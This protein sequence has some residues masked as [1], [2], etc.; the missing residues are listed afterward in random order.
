MGIGVVVHGIIESPGW[1]SQE[2]SVR[3]YRHN[4]RVIEAL[5]QSDSEWPFITRSMFSIL[6]LRPSFD[7]RI[8]QYETAIIHFA[9]VYKNMYHLDADWVR[10]FERLLARLCWTRAIVYN[11]F[12]CI[13]HKWDSDWPTESFMHDPPI[14]PKRWT[15]TCGQIKVEPITFAGAID[16][17]YT[18]PV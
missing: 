17:D 9:G 13:F 2:T 3:A 11:E 18:P 1:A 10:K 5:P 7:I 14:P 8:A 6:P 4:R 16:G 12:S 15:L